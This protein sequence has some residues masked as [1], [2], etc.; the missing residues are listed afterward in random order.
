MI[1]KLGQILGAL[2]M[3]GGV[4]SCMIQ[5]PPSAFPFLMM[6]GALLYGGCRIAAWLGS[7]QA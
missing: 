7:K 5:H 2:L 4:T 3:A 6:G 1:L